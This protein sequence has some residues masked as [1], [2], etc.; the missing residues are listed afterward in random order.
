MD[1]NAII[2]TRTK[3]AKTAKRARKRYV[4]KRHAEKLTLVNMDYNKFIMCTIYLP[5]IRVFY[6]IILWLDLLSLRD[7]RDDILLR[8]RE[9]WGG[10]HR[11]T[12]ARHSMYLQKRALQCIS[13]YKSVISHSNH[14]GCT[15]H[16][17]CIRNNSH[18]VISSSFNLWREL[19]LI[20]SIWF[21]RFI[22]QSV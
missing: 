10:L 16:V 19:N 17:L 9:K 7:G 22:L 3:T 1:S 11:R 15:F 6:W 14:F 12:P 4:Q 13:G 20:V 2:V 18:I 8:W 5:I 21:V